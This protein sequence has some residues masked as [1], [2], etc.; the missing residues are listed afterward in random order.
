MFPSRASSILRGAE[1]RVLSVV[2]AHHRHVLGEV[3]V[4]PG[5]R[6]GGRDLDTGSF[7]DQ[8]N[9]PRFQ[10]LFAMGLALDA[11]VCYVRL[12][13]CGLFVDG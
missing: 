3:R 7:P 12:P 13:A 6:D 9:H 4:Q 5:P 8:R 10:F 2:E 11:E 1:L